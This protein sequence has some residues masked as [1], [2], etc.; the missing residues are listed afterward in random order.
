[1]KYVLLILLLS[2]NSYYNGSA[3]ARLHMIA[4][5]Q[6]QNR[7]VQGKVS[8]STGEPLVGVNIT[9]V[10]TT[11]GTITDYGGN[12]SILLTGDNSSLKFS[13][14]GYQE[15]SVSTQGQTSLNITL[16]ESSE[17][18]EEVVVVG[19]GTRKKATLTGAVSSVGAETFDSKGVVS[20]PVQ[21]L[22]GQVPGMVI[23]RNSS[24]PGREEWGYKIRGQASVNDPGTL[25][26]VDGMPGDMSNLNPDDIENI[27]FL[28]DAAAAVY[29]SRAAGGV[30]LITTKR[31]KNQ[32]AKIAYKGNVAVRL[33]SMQQTFM[34]M[35][36][37]AYS[38]EE[39]LLNTTTGGVEPMIGSDPGA[40]PYWAI[41][42]MKTK[43]PRYMGT[44]QRYLTGPQPAS[45]H[46]IGFLEYDMNDV[47]WGNALSQ[48]HSLSIQGGGESGRYNL[49]AGYMHNGSPLKSEWGDDFSK[50]YTVRANNDINV[51]Q[52]LEL[53]L[54][55]SYDRRENTYPGS[56]PRNNN[57]NPPGSPLL[58]PQGNPFGWASN[59]TPVVQ[60][61]FGGQR[62]SASNNLRINISPKFHIIEGLDVIGNVY[63]NPSN[64]NS[65]EYQNKVVWYDYQDIP[66]NF[67][68]P[69]TNWVNR[70]SR[71][72]MSQQYQGYLNYKK[73][74]NQAH[75]F[76]LMSGA[77]Y[78]KEKMTT[79]S[80]QKSNLDVEALHSLNTGTIFDSSTDDVNAWAMA[81]YFGRL[82]YDYKGK[83]IAELLGRYDGTSKFIVG[84]KWYPFFGASAGWR[85]SEESFMK[86][87]G[88]FDNLKIRA[89]Y[90]EIGNQ[91]G[92]GY[93]DYIALLDMNTASNLTAN[94]P[95]F[96]SESAPAYGQTVTQQ[97]VI[98]T[99]R[100]W[101]V[102][103]TT[104]IG[105]DF[106]ILN[107]RLSGSFDYFIKKNDNMLASVTY[108]A[109]FG[110]IAPQTN[111]GK[112]QV[113]GW[114]LSLGWRDKTGGLSYYINANLSNDENKLLEMENADTKTWNARTQYLIG[115]PLNTYWGMD[116]G[117]LIE[118]EMELAAYKAKVS[119]NI[120]DPE[121]LRIGDMM[122]EDINGDGVI[123]REDV[124]LLGDNM[125]HY[126]FG[127]NMG[128]AYKGFDL[129]VAIQGV[130][131]QTIIRN[132][133]AATMLVA[134]I[135]QNQ[136]NIWYGRN[137]SDIAEKLA[138]SQVTF[139]DNDGTTV[140][141]PLQLA[142]VNKDPYAVPKSVHN[143][144]LR[145]YNYLYS[146][147]FYRKQNGM[148][149]RMKN[150]TIGY[151]LPKHF[152]S[153]LKIEKLRFYFS[154][155]DVFEIT[156]T[157]DGW[158]PESR[159]ENPFGGTSGSNGYPFMRS[160]SFGIDLTF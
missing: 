106:E 11:N 133:S 32:K 159:A 142:P 51:A 14:L 48:S 63:F 92:I 123:S 143:N 52:W 118:D 82:N 104:N 54:D 116:A 83:Y 122:Y 7:T 50:R 15:Q 36:Q 43:D 98:S 28:K 27:S 25:V 140:T 139:I 102:I 115:Y 39:A 134:N 100:T 147:A 16:H 67:V 151:T 101:E 103:K 20:D 91:S 56:N 71:E 37:W 124:M 107:N 80:T 105:L 110:A 9:E 152:I 108:P 95:I 34:T 88:I 22:Q 30:I 44:V 111:S 68:N 87:N 117:K 149:V 94:Y 128:G 61:K 57:G 109:V 148:Y 24:A 46:D 141:R 42:A 137:Y 78:E 79:F 135:Y 120:I 21:A 76:D 130:G 150:I 19:Y 35:E 113:K 74:F 160:Y 49:S 8:D 33:P 12:F 96:G 129:S 125:P 114:E 45:I 38:I 112:M 47:T 99:E 10:G 154:G 4:G 72:S 64:R 60:T 3:Y 157:E 121:L 86:A 132:T 93:Y 75:S 73:T 26:L 1:M 29:G 145:T 13:Y 17:L 146:D 6:Q 58:T 53:S 131:K 119:S 62:N 85:I 59:I 158:D 97:N 155:N 23:T 127:V 84:K 31:G 136:G 55:L 77:S 90:G 144:N 153:R 138:G 5:I 41:H 156:R 70:L 89:S 69:S 2:G 18:L 81:S 126:S 66:Y 65:L 40:F